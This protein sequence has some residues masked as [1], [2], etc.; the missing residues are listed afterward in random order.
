MTFIPLSYTDPQAF[1]YYEI[2]GAS[3]WGSSTY[4]GPD[5]S[6]QPTVMELSIEESHGETF[7]HPDGKAFKVMK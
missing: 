4:E 7:C 3:P 2:H 1:S 5:G 6:R